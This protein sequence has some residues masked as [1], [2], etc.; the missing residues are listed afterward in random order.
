MVN[1]RTT[2]FVIGCVFVV[3]LAASVATT[4]P[5]PPPKNKANVMH[6]SVA[7]LTRILPPPRN[8]IHTGTPADWQ[9]I[10]QKLR[11]QFPDHYKSFVETYGDGCIDNFLFIYNPFEPAVGVEGTSFFVDHYYSF[12]DRLIRWEQ[13]TGEHTPVWPEKDGFIQIGGTMN[14]GQLLWH[15]VGTP[16]DWTVRV[17]GERRDW[18]KEGEFE[19]YN[20]GLVEFLYRLLNQEIDAPEMPSRFFANHPLQYGPFRNLPDEFTE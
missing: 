4:A 10:E 16:N 7:K 17:A 11:I 5:V 9:R 14:S 2:W 8:P 18:M 12:R 19:E 15:T 6:P 20:V 1:L 13:K 3:T